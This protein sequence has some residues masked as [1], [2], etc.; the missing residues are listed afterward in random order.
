MY[1]ST[2]SWPR[3][4]LEASGQL[5]TSADLPPGKELPLPIDYEAVWAPEPVWTTWRE[6]KSHP[7]RDTNCET[8]AVQPV[9]GRYTDCTIPTLLVRE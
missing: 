2:D 4:L 3:H 8:S 1:T 6:E 5:H 9:V 7:H